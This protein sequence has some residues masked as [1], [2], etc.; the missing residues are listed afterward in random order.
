MFRMTVVAVCGLLAAAV[1]PARAQS[2]VEH[3][4]G[5]ALAVAPAPAPA[6]ARLD[7]S[8][9]GSARLGMSQPQ[10][11]D[12]AAA[13]EATAAPRRAGLRHRGPGVALMLVGAAGVVTGLLLEESI[14]TVLGAGTGLVGLYL[15][16]R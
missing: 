3:R 16:L 13:R 15:F 8:L 4:P 6:P 7:R 2:P 1:S 5:V 9:V 11:A 12:T 14:I 10:P